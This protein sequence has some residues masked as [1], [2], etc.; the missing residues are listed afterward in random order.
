[1]PP[2]IKVTR[3]TPDSHSHCAQTPTYVCTCCTRRRYEPA[4]PMTTPPTPRLHAFHL[5]A[6]RE[7]LRETAIRVLPTNPSSPLA[8]VSITE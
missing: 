3:R 2:A 8:Y 6:G 1:M 4:R 7:L 5:Y